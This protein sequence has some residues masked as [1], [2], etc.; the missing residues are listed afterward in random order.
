MCTIPTTSELAHILF[1]EEA[2]LLF[3]ELHQ[4]IPVETKCERC[5]S[6]VFVNRHRGSFRCT[7]KNCRHEVGRFRWTFFDKSKLSLDKVLYL[8]YEWLK[9][10][11]HKKLCCD[12]GLAKSTV[13]AYIMYFR[14]LVA[15][16]LDESH[17]KIGGEGI[18]VEIDESKLAKRKYNRGHTV[19]G[20]WVLGGVER[21]PERRCFLVIVDTRDAATLEKAI[22]MYVNP[23]STIITDCWKGYGW[24]ASTSDYV[25][26]T[27]NH[28]KCFKDPDSGA[29]TNTIEG[30]W[31]ALKRKIPPR[32]RTETAIGQSLLEFIWRRKN[33]HCLWDAFLKALKEYVEVDCE[34]EDS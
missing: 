16:M 33:E 12:T 10:A 27:V 8:G 7:K 18:T 4:I 13:T 28:S 34:T 26:Q 9:G 31:S 2:A 21:T 5:G 1:D 11:S 15:N 20:V 25:H 32:T 17:V 24:L 19:Q 30:T 14:E 29:H 3:L 6:S 23:Q 22:R